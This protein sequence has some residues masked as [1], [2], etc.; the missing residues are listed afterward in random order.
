M[1]AH[2]KGPWSLGKIRDGMVEINGHHHEGL[3][4]VVWQMNDDEVI[5]ERSPEKEANAHLIAAAPDLLAALQAMVGRWEPDT[6]GADRRMWEAAC[7]AIA[8]AKGEPA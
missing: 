2:T 8:K 6:E 3:A 4:Q 5:G 1:S 7:D